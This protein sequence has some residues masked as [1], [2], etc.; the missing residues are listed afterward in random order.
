MGRPGQ[1]LSEDPH[2][3]RNADAFKKLFLYLF[4]CLYLAML[5]LCCCVWAF[6]SCR[7]HGYSLA[8]VRVLVI[9]V[10]SLVGEHRLWGAQASV[11]VACGL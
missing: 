6:S 2:W 9:V 7:D 5:G 4:I 10:A 8:V 1:I 3:E 11:I